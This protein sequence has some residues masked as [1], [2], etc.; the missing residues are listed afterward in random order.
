MNHHSCW[1]YPQS[2]CFFLIPTIL[3]AL[4]L[5]PRSRWPGN[6]PN[7]AL[8]QASEG[9]PVIV[10]WNSCSYRFSLNKFL[11]NDSTCFILVIMVCY[12]VS[13][14][15]PAQIW[16]GKLASKTKKLNRK[17]SMN[18]CIKRVRFH[19]QIIKGLYKR[20]SLDLYECFS[21]HRNTTHIRF[22]CMGFRP[23]RNQ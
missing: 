13:H 15:I 22:P 18:V 14:S 3:V 17:S 7:R 11:R 6:V 21:S 16:D 12:W 4:R 8:T 9:N 2:I 19:W 1:L 5:P 23:Q 20:V 10:Q